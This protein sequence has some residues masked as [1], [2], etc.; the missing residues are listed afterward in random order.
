[1]QRSKRFQKH[2]PMAYPYEISSMNLPRT[3]SDICTEIAEDC[4]GLSTDRDAG[5]RVIHDAR[6]GAVAIG[7]P[8]II[9]LAHRHKRTATRHAVKIESSSRL[10]PDVA[11]TGA[12]GP[13]VFQSQFHGFEVNRTAGHAQP[14]R[15]TG[16][17]FGRQIR[18]ERGEH[19]VS[20]AGQSRH[21]LL[22]QLKTVDDEVGGV[23][24][25]DP[26]GGG[27]DQQVSHCD[28]VH[29]ATA[30]GAAMVRKSLGAT[31]PPVA[32][33]SACSRCVPGRIDPSAHRMTVV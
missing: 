22:P 33:C 12:H 13:H 5:Q 32:S 27:P 26:A 29:H 4:V 1:M 15:D 28:A 24:P 16:R 2:I 8:A 20:P 19:V 30:P 6:R 31:S 11:S 9:D 18:T 7:A 21:G 17:T 23:A 10:D 25:A 14:T 3:D